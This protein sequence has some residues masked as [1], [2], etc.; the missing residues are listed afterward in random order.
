MTEE[1]M[2]MDEDTRKRCDTAGENDNVIHWTVTGDMFE[3]PK[4]SISTEMIQGLSDIN[5]R[6]SDML[7]SATGV[8]ETYRKAMPSVSAISDSLRSISSV[9]K[10]LPDYSSMVRG[11]VPA[12]SRLAEVMQELARG[13][14]F[15]DIFNVVR[16]IA[17][18]AKRVEILGRANWPMYLVDDEAVCSGLDAVSP[19]ATD[20][21]LMDA[22]AE[23]AYSA[24]GSGWLDEIRS[25]W[26]DHDELA[27]GE[28]G[29]LTRALERHKNGDYE[30][31]VALLMNL[32]EG[33][34]EK[35]CP[36]EV[37][38]LE[39]EQAEMFDLHADKLGLNPSH[40]GK[41]KARNLTNA[42]DKVLVMVLLSENGWYTFQHAADY[43]VSVI[44]T[45]TMN[46]D[47]AEHN[48]LRNKICHGEQ[49]EYGTK[50]HSL[51]AILVTDVMIRFGAALLAECA[52]ARRDD[53]RSGYGS[54]PM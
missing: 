53:E 9:M 10:S 54:T 7:A 40:S 49:T 16:P 23:I 36:S 52:V 37:K 35:Y 25:R 6:Y 24:L 32:F 33:L 1:G 22:V 41:G 20:E 18:K 26:E 30:G 47:I 51:K 14:I 3:V 21:E 27:N 38:K 8:S 42:K 2:S 39:G 15:K 31:C 17:L 5:K 34:I 46:A 45:N 19:N 13:I 50:E 28:K 12:L 43:I 11:M 29:V 48:P 44:L 4:F